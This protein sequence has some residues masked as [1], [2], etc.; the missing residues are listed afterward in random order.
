MRPLKLTLTAFGP[1]HETEIIDFEALKPYDL[2]VISGNT[3]AGKTS[4]FDGI[5]YALFGGASG[6]DRKEAT[7]LRSDFAPDGLPTSAELLFSLRGKAYR[8][9]RQLPY[10]K[11]G[12]KSQTPGKLNFMRLI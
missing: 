12:N 7:S 5:S 11:S 9:F 2:F 4:I 10:T 6:E 8:V 3:G 1:Y